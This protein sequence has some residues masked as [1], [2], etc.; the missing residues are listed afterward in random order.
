MNSKIQEYLENHRKLW[1]WIEEETRRRKR[2]VQKK[3]IF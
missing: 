2:I 3:R 1:L